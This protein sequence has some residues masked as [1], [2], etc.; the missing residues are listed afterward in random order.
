VR[1]APQEL[2]LS[3]VDTTT[4]VYTYRSTVLGLQSMSKYH[5]VIISLIS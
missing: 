3:N 5:M 1:N 2:K 4:R